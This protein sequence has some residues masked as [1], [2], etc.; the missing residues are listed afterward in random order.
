M[1]REHP[2]ESVDGQLC[3][4]GRQDNRADHRG[5]RIGILQPVVQEGKGCLDAQRNE[6]EQCA[7]FIQAGEGR[8]RKVAARL[9]H[10]ANASQQQDAGQ[11]LDA[12]IPHGGEIS[13]ARPCPQN[14]EDRCNGRQFPEHEQGHHV[15]REGRRDGGPCIG[16]RHTVLQTVVCVPRIDRVQQ[17][18]EQECEAENVAE[19]V[20]PIEN[21]L[22]TQRVAGQQ[23]HVPIR[24]RN[25]QDG[26]DGRGNG[27]SL[28][29]AANRQ[30]KGAKADSN[31][32]PAGIQH[33]E[34]TSHQ[35]SSPSSG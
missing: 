26:N 11:N 2:R 8:D 23:I 7:R 1:A 18:R 24:D 27:Q 28:T 12:Q 3:R 33:G 34:Q 6:D 31:Q 35:C 21:H 29:H 15:A 32:E 22:D 13:S 20:D 17:R 19:I 25:Q 30:E 5:L 10:I 14:Q 9:V 4:K 16:N